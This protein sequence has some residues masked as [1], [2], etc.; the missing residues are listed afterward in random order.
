MTLDVG[1]PAG[2][3]VQVD[4]I[5]NRSIGQPD[6]CVENGPLPGD[7]PCLQL[8]GQG[9]DLLVARRG[10]ILMLILMLLHDI[11]TAEDDQI[12]M[13]KVISIPVHG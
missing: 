12:V 9:S 5:Q 3:E 13:A 7:L 6:L 10:G 4:H 1:R 11:E 2:F 8:L